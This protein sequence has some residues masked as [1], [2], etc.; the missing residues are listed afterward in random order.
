MPERSG[1]IVKEDV[2]NILRLLSSRDDL[3]Q[4]DLSSHLGISLGKINYLLKSL[5]RKGLLE[6]KNFTAGNQKI[7]KVKYFLTRRGLEEKVSLTYHFLKKKES[8]YNHIKNEWVQLITQEIG[9][10]GV[11]DYK[12]PGFEISGLELDKSRID[13]E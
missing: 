7:K 6:I 8:E 11:E 5:V 10:Q 9:A 2:F 12:M 4:R 13:D 3:T 1:Q